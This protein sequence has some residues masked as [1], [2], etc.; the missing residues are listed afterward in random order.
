MKINLSVGDLVGVPTQNKHILLGMITNIIKGETFN[1]R[2]NIM[3]LNTA[4]G[5][6]MGVMEDTTI[7]YRKDYIAWRK[8]NLSL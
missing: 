4:W 7:Q 2:Y 3:W 5:T 6:D 1:V 8:L